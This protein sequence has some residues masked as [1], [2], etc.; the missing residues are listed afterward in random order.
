MSRPRTLAADLIAWPDRIAILQQ[1]WDEKSIRC[2]DLVAWYIS[3]H[4]S[5]DDPREDF[6]SH[7]TV[8][9][10]RRVVALHYRDD[11]WRVT[12]TKR[13]RDLLDR[14]RHA[15]KSVAASTPRRRTTVA[16]RGRRRRSTADSR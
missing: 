9:E 15:A 16:T 7:L 11:C 4:P 1:V 10:H 12:V 3:A 13:G 14:A 8:M 2:R 6:R 5:D